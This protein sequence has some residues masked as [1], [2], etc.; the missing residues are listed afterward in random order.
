MSNESA[1]SSQD[2]R[3][4]RYDS[5]YSSPELA[6]R[7]DL[8]RH[9]TENSNL[10]PLVKGV[11]GIGKTT[12]IRHLL[13]LAPENW[14]P[15]EI[16]ADVMLQ[17]AA[18]QATLARQFGLDDRGDD[19]LGRLVSRFD[20]LRHDGL[21]PVIIV[22]DAHLLPEASIIVLLR[23]HERGEGGSPLA[24]ILL[25]AQP[26]I[27]D[28]L[29]TPQLRVMN[30]QSLQMLDLPVF[31]R[32]QTERFLQHLLSVDGAIPSPPVSP[33]QI[34]RI[35]RETG[36]LPGLI[37]QRAK[38]LVGANQDKPAK[39]DPIEFISSRTALGGGVVLI[40][41]L[42]ALIY[43]DS[44]NALFSG[45][46]EPVA[47]TQDIRL[48]GDKVVPLELPDAQAEPETTP[49]QTLPEPLPDIVQDEE[50]SPEDIELVPEQPEETEETGESAEEGVGETALATP[51]LPAEQQSTAITT[52]LPP[53]TEPAPEAPE[54]AP[55]PEPE[56]KEATRQADQG[57]EPEPT[58]AVV[59][60]TVTTQTTVP[61]PGETQEERVASA[62]DAISKPEVA[63]KQD[64][65]QKASPAPV[66]P[67]SVPV[68]TGQRPVVPRG[69][70]T[71]DPQ[72]SK[73]PTPKATAPI[74]LTPA[75]PQVVQ[76]R[77]T[78]PAPAAKTQ[79]VP[80]EKRPSVLEE[81]GIRE[82]APVEERSTQLG[83]DDVPTVKSAPKPPNEEQN[84]PVLA[85]QATVSV[86][87]RAGAARLWREDWLL[88][89]EAT[90]FTIQLAGFQDEGAIPGFLRRHP[91]A[92][93]IAYYRT[94]RKGRLWF[95]VLYGVYPDRQKAN[96]ALNRLPE[97]LRQ[98]GV[99]IRA[100]DSVH[101][102]I[103]PR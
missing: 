17:P 85:P 4:E 100:M 78:P 70:H 86:S 62:A 69:K 13:D 81:G 53:M 89:Q 98:S 38:A 83:R 60:D 12:F 22:D 102:E 18:L 84:K 35:H 40:F 51:E 91:L 24:Q 28:L 31:T 80:V 90:G 76:S 19:L 68:R 92:G 79:V 6:Q 56:P 45:D 93:S 9:L 23:L 65:E 47:V 103:S 59:G 8:L 72:D 75:R 2:I 46:E 77:A 20:D 54:P 101:K 66:Q 5:Y 25:F 43:Q 58:A 32:E 44:I 52:Q 88:R 36:G 97:K 30:L 26:E 39:P 1:N 29:K 71:A 50:I 11:E 73:P 49:E 41:V 99:W 87:A 82:P 67:E 48:P 95:P 63:V 96:E 64:K 15:V 7:T 61:A 55:E 37:K 3:S 33:V 74:T 27:D 34:E 42:L 94:T 10:I 57:V 21:L 14:I 16:D